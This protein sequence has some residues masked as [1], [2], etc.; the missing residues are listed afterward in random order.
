MYARELVQLH[1]SKASLLEPVNADIHETFVDFVHVYPSAYSG[2]KSD[3]K[4]ASQMLAKIQQTLQDRCR[5]RRVSLPQFAMPQVETKPLKELRY[6]F[7]FSFR[8]AA[9]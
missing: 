4:L 9:A 8:K 7:V 1:S 5:S 3:R 6:P 2:E